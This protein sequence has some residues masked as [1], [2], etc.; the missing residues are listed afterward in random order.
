MQDSR[1]VLT[2]MM[3]TSKKPKM[4][5]R[6]R[7]KQNKIQDEITAKAAQSKKNMVFNSLSATLSYKETE[8]AKEPCFQTDVWSCRSH[9]PSIAMVAL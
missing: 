4:H 5:K 9:A 2:K 7:I 8:C 6:K 1:E 3:K